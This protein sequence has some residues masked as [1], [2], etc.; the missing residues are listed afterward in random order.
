[1]KRL[2]K[3]QILEMVRYHA[4]N[5]LK[6]GAACPD[7]FRA[8][9]FYEYYNKYSCQFD[10]SNANDDEIVDEYKYAIESFQ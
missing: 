3:E 2:S 4:K 6:Y 10:F 8:R 9:D 1:M 7:D 5:D